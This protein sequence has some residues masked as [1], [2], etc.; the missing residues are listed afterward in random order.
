[1]VYSVSKCNIYIFEYI[2]CISIS[3]FIFISI[4]PSINYICTQGNGG[5]GRSSLLYI[6]IA[7]Y[8][9]KRGGGIQSR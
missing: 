6:S 8:M 7:Y 5:G 2:V 9:K 1:M 3:T 4:G